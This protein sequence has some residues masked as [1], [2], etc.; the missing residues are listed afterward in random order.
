MKTHMRTHTRARTH[1]HTRTHIHTVLGDR[2]PER[3]NNYY[4]MSTHGNHSLTRS[5]IKRQEGT[6]AY[7]AK[8]PVARFNDLSVNPGTRL[9]G[10]EN[11][12]PQ[13]IL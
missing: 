10:G 2:H 12:F 9:L 13:A 8:V 1:M 11:L 3:V 5:V 6:M 4:A 7:L